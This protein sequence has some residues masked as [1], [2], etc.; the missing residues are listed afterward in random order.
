MADR[1]SYMYLCLFKRLWLQIDHALASIHSATVQLPQHWMKRLTPS[2]WSSRHCNSAM[3]TWTT[4]GPT[5]H[6]CLDDDLL[7]I[8]SC[9]HFPIRHYCTS[10][11]LLSHW[12]SWGFSLTTHRIFFHML[13]IFL[14]SLW[15]GHEWRP[16]AIREV[17]AA[18][19]Q[20]KA[21]WKKV[22]AMQ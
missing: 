9:A 7:A 21:A 18:Q 3:V 20:E 8:C 10:R 11:G 22:L 5:L 19:A 2:P 14:E 16:W 4:F 6:T 12:Y 15:A 13:G 17:L 1:I